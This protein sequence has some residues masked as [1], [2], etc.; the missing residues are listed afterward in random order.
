[1][2]SLK[3]NLQYFSIEALVVQ[4]YIYEALTESK[5]QMATLSHLGVAQLNPG[6]VIK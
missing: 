4:C 5:S 1:M 2:Y 3:P 6:I